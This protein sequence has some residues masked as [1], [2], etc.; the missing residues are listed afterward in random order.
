MFFDTALSFPVQWSLVKGL[1]FPASRLVHATDFPY[2]AVG[3]SG[4]VALGAM[5]AK[6][7]G[8]FTEEVEED[9]AYRNALTNL[10][11]RLKQEWHKAFG[12]MAQ[13]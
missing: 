1:G 6:M 3:D 2:T 5:S 13:L 7:S 11:P 9:I 8:Q 10:F 12:E 4:A